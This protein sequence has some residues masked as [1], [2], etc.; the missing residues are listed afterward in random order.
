MTEKEKML[1]GQLYN[2]GDPVLS[3]E[4]E[5]TRLLVQRINNLN[6][7]HKKERIKLMYELL[8][9]SGNDLWIEPPFF[10]DYG[11]N[12][13]LGNNVYMNY[14]CCILDAMEV[15]IGNNTMLGPSVQVYTSTH[16]MDIKTR[17]EM[18]EY[19]KPIH[20]G[21]D[22]WIGGGAIIC[23]GVRIGNGVVVGAGAVVT[24]DIPDHV[25]VAGNPAKLIRTING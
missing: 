10:C 16:P 19:A 14:N 7:N 23:P 24:K 18:L 20:I 13:H 15:N 22:V 1:T 6:E 17:S 12:I 3:A 21:N 2:A 9:K 4:R 25:F 11:Y 5:K 8:D